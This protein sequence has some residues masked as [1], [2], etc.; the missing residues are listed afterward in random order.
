[1]LWKGIH[2]IHLGNEILNFRSHINEAREQICIPTRQGIY[3][4]PPVIKQNWKCKSKT[5]ELYIYTRDPDSRVP[6]VI[7]L[8]IAG[9]WVGRGVIW[10][11]YA[12]LAKYL[13][14]DQTRDP[15]K[16]ISKHYSPPVE[17]I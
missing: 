4:L 13:Q 17:R 15:G 8:R 11:L 6:P 2:C 9:V 3:P 5:G 14:N 1:M 7:I 16:F 10:A 12:L